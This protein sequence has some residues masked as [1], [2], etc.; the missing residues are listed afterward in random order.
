M[1]IFD[2]KVGDKIRDIE[3]GDCYFEGTVTS[4]NPLM[5][6]FERELWCNEFKEIHNGDVKELQWYLLEVYIDDKWV[7]IKL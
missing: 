2:I 4:L 6:L 3:D 5:Y 1:T 7:K